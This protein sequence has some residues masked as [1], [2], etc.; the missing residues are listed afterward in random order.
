HSKNCS[1][2]TQPLST[3]HQRYGT[4]SVAT[5][6]P[7]PS[8]STKKILPMPHHNPSAGSGRNGYPFQ[9]LRFSMAI[10]V[11]AKLSLSSR[12]QPTSPP[13]LPCP[14][15]LLRSREVS[16]SSHPTLMQLLPNSNS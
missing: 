12:S 8:P 9:V 7:P 13:V 5:N 11:W 15:A 16:S 1:K 3:N 10:T 6:Q 2:S 4:F 14:M